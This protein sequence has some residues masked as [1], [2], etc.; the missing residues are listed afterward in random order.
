MS[1]LNSPDDQS[2]ASRTCGENACV[3]DEAALLRLV[4]AVAAAHPRQLEV[5][6]AFQPLLLVRNRLLGDCVETGQGESLSPESLPVDPDVAYETLLPVLDAVAEGFPA[7][8][9][10]A[11]R[12]REC[13][14][15]LLASKLCRGWLS[16]EMSVVE[17]LSQ[18]RGLPSELLPFVL[19]QTCRILM[20]RAAAGLP[21]AEENVLRQHCPYCGSA[22][23]LSVVHG[24]G[25]SRSLV[26]GLC[27]RYWRFKRTA[28][29]ACGVDAPGNMQSLYV[30]EQ[31]HERAV[32]CE[33]CGRYVLEVD[34]RHL[35]LQPG[36]CQALALGL[37]HLDALVQE[38]GKLPLA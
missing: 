13:L 6:R 23:E 38:E 20:A 3:L 12:L 26:C 8:W 17:D 4:D 33:G 16:G 30:E 21:E 5:I 24:A 29:P 15:P 9:E 2:G 19:G 36:Q 11:A 35:E 10:G 1:N 7:M 22:P 37:G 34:I 27:G 32:W 14:S 31:P 25:G 28:C 18:K